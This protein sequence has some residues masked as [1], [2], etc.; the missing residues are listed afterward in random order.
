M[1]I[2]RLFNNK[3]AQAKAKTEKKKEEEDHQA[4]VDAV[5]FPIKN[6]SDKDQKDAPPSLR[7]ASYRP[8]TNNNKTRVLVSVQP[9]ES[10]KRIPVDIVCVVDISGSMS[11]RATTK[12]ASGKEEGSP[13]TMLSLVSHAVRTV[14]SALGEQDRLALVAFDDVGETRYKLEYMNDD[15]KK[16]LYK[17]ADD[18]QT[19]GGTN[20]WAGIKE[21]LDTLGNA[22]KTEGRRLGSVVILTDGQP[23]SSPAEGEAGATRNYI[24]SKKL[25]GNVSTFGF[26]YGINTTMLAGVAEAAGGTY[27]FIPDSTIVGTAFVNWTAN[28]LSTA[29]QRCVLSLEALDGASFAEKQ[30]AKIDKVSWGLRYQ[31]P[32]VAYGQSQDVVIE[33]ENVPEGS[34]NFLR[35]TLNYHNGWGNFDEETTKCQPSGEFYQLV[36]TQY[37]R[38]L[39]VNALRDVTKSEGLQKAIA[40]IKSDGE[41]A[42]F[43]QVSALLEDLEGQ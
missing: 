2:G 17:I 42:T 20:I 4:N 15:N 28:F 13:L 39:A 37:A 12:D 14:A 19:R 18:L 43:P 24:E 40:E 33:M 10:V 11:S 41:A 8:D 29:A 35:A 21:G 9:P 23:T 1:P 5:V 27:C 34:E 16:R 25:P 22:A 31:I 32:S 26:G 36:K 38:T 7:I 6:F 3:A 30:V